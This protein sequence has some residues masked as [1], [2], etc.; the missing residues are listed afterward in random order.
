METGQGHWQG[1]LLLSHSRVD[2]YNLAGWGAVPAP[3]PRGNVPKP[4]AP[5]EQPLLMAITCPQS[6]VYQDKEQI[7]I[8]LESPVL[9][10]QRG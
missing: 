8:Y 6:R 5:G 7:F 4:H 3:T 1:H 10:E 9:M 2:A